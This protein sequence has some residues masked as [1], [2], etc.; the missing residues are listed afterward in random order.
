MLCLILERIV[1]VLAHAGYSV[2]GSD[3]YQLISSE[4]KNVFIGF[5][6]FNMADWLCCRSIYLGKLRSTE[7]GVDSILSQHELV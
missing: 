5:E 1:T 7:Q 3:Q 4:F 2:P 6:I